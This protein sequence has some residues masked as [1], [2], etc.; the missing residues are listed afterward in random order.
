M[1]GENS[2]LKIHTRVAQPAP[3]APQ[4]KAKAA[5]SPQAKRPAKRAR[6]KLTLTTGEK[7]IRNTAIAGAA[8]LCVLAV[9]NIDQ[10]WSD[11]AINGIRQAMT[12][13]V[14]WDES[15]GRLSFVRAL[16]PETALVFLNLDSRADLLPPVSGA[17]TH[18]W[19]EEQPWLEYAPEPGA[20]VAAAAEGVV[21]A[22]AQ[23]MSGD[24]IVL[25]EHDGGRETVY[26]YLASANVRVGQAVGAGDVIGF[27]RQEPNA[28]LYFELRENGQPADPTERFK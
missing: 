5:P 12:M 4:K 28:R 16:V 2:R 15:I 26:G 10:P 27:A 20:P 18:A 6:P 3:F 1:Q 21:T 19:S 24:W 17:A 8:F 9:R 7:L 23:G 22:S 14:D 11:T 25:I 13:R